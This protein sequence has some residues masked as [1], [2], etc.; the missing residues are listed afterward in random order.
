MS[1]TAKA[2]HDFHLQAMKEAIER[3][4][5]E[6]IAASEAAHRTKEKDEKGPGNEE[7]DR[8]IEL[9]YL[10]DYLSQLCS[11]HLM[12]LDHI[13]ETLAAL[14]DGDEKSEG[15]PIHRH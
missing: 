12:L 1:D 13:A 15:K 5:P 10:V 8:T 2:E 7:L 6:L 4:K 11:P 9:G 14:E 3:M